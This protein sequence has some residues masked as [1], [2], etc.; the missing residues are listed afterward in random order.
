MVKINSIPKLG[1][2]GFDVQKLQ[3]ALVSE[4]FYKGTIDGVFGA[5]TKDSVSEF[6]KSKGLNGSG[7][8]GPKTLDFLG[9]EV[10]AINP[11]LNQKCITKDLVGKNEH[12]RIHPTM[13]LMLEQRIFKNGVIG[14]CWKNADIAECLKEISDA[15]LSMHIREDLGPNKGEIVGYI[16]GIIGTY[17]PKGT[18]DHWCMSTDQLMI[19][20]I[21]DFFQK[22][23]PVEDS[24]HCVTVFNASKNIPGL[25]VIGEA[26]EG[27]FFIVQY[28]PKTSGHTGLNLK[29]N[30][31]IMTT[32]EGNTGDSS[33]NNGDGYY[34]RKRDLNNLG[35]A[36]L[37]GTIFVYPN[38]KLPA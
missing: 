3:V 18:G 38:N 5:K 4:G 28:W 26:V 25:V 1:D 14:E 23:S 31:K 12:R 19:A 2:I 30:G 7:V 34:E 32:R 35:S 37:L 17:N 20:F 36:R 11:V 29:K 15:L 8:I 27:G 22:E 9:F 16:Q 6:Q 10:E 24:E 21:E 33:V 13:R